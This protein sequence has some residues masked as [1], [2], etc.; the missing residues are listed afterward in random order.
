[1]VD[2]VVTNFDYNFFPNAFNVDLLMETNDYE[3]KE[4]YGTPF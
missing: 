4:V 2:V 1:M 3:I